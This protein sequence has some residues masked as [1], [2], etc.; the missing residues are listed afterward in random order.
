MN[1]SGI[2]SITIP[3]DAST[4][5]TVLPPGRVWLKASVLDHSAAVCDL[6]AIET[7]A[8]EASFFQPAADEKFLA[9]PLPANSIKKLKITRS[10]IKKISQPYASI[11]GQAAEAAGAFYTRVS[12]RLRHKQRA[13]AIWDYEHLVL[14]HFPDIYQ[15]RCINHSAYHVERAAGEY[16]SS[17]FAPGYITLIAI[18]DLDN[19]NVNNPLQPRVSLNRLEQI[20]AFIKQRMSPFAAKKIRVINPRY[21]SLQVEFNVEFKPS[22]D[23]SAYL[24]ILNQDI[25]RFLSPWAFSEQTTEAISFGGSIHRSTLL[26]FVERRE[27]VDFVGAFKMHHYRNDTAD[28]V[29]TDVEAAQAQTARSIFVSHP[30]HLIK[31]GGVC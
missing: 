30:Q 10:E 1:A 8:A 2:V 7:Q 12:E 22:F 6:I 24:D 15:L 16:F 28:S 3:A 9:R 31:N 17:E 13:L 18:A 14:Q 29:E 25:I 20:S 19:G 27:Y 23:P 21:E 4:D 5:N 11:E 26:H